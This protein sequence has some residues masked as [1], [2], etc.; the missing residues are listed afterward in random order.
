[1]TLLNVHPE[2][3]ALAQ[4]LLADAEQALRGARAEAR[5][6]Y[7]VTAKDTCECVRE[8]LEHA[9]RLMTPRPVEAAEIARAA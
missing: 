2:D 3:A 4:Q 8:T 7:L 5:A 1:V 9:E 6:G